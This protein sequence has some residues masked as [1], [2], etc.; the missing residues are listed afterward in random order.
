MFRLR[1]TCMVKI[2]L[3][4][5]SPTWSNRPW[6]LKLKHKH[7]KKRSELMKIIKTKHSR[8]HE[9]TVEIQTFK[10]WCVMKVFKKRR[11]EACFISHTSCAESI[12][13]LGGAKDRRINWIAF[14]KLIRFLNSA[15]VKSFVWNRVQIVRNNCVNAQLH[16]C[17]VTFAYVGIK[18]YVETIKGICSLI[19]TAG[20]WIPFVP[21]PWVKLNFEVI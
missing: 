1:L 17:G 5:T 21:K 6:G 3:K 14:V 7:K 16:N 12:Q 10:P 18:Q 13:E 9:D 11:V 20:S 15:H 2:C 19:A 8:D 4:K